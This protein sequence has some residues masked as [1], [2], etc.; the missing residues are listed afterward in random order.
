MEIQKHQTNGT[1]IA[2]VLSEQTLIHTP[3]DGLQLLADLYYQGFGEIILHERQVTPQFFDLKT[4]IA[5]E[6]LQK[7]ANYRVKLA[8]V[9]DFADYGS[10]SLNDFI[11]ESNKGRQVNF[12]PSV[13]EALDRLSR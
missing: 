10:K 6:V 7:F 1:S 13:E 4:G 12:V 9:G 11:Y 2:E 8:I 3:D 5:G